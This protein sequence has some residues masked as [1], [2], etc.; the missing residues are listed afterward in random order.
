MTYDPHD[1]D[2][3]IHAFD[4]AVLDRDETLALRV[5]HS[6]FA[7]VLVHP[8]TAVMPRTRWLEVLGDYVVDGFDVQE[9][10]V[11]SDGDT[12]SVLTRA[13]M[14]AVVLG[15]RR[16]G[17][18]VMSDIWRLTVDGWRVWRRHS[19]PLSAGPMPGA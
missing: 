9:R 11:D 4:R 15:E 16:D 2:A 7:L 8:T 12:A 19:T 17:L 3:M 1:L 5:L 14:A 18:F 13:L 10:I 6:E